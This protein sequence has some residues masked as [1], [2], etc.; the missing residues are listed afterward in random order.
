MVL[1]GNLATATLTGCGNYDM[2]D[3]QYTFN[4]AIIFGE[5]CVKIIEIEKWVDYDGEQIQITTKDSLFFK[6]HYN[7]A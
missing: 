4:K 2:L 7:A 1:A 3:T 6:I 5:D